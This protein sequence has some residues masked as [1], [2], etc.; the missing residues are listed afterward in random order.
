[1]TDFH[2]EINKIL[3]PYDFSDAAKKALDYASFLAKRTNGEILLVHV[4]EGVLGASEPLYIEA[5]INSPIVYENDIID[6]CKT[7]LTVIAQKLQETGPVKIT[8]VTRAGSAH[9]KIVKIANAVKADLIVMGTH[10]MSGFRR[11]ILGSNTTRV[12]SEATCPV[13]SIQESVP[14]PGF[15][16]I[17]VPFRDEPHSREKVDYAIKMAELFEADIHVLGIDSDGGK[18]AHVKIFREAEQ[19]KTIIKKHRINCE[20]NIITGAH[21]SDQILKHA[22]AKKADLIVIMADMDR[23]SISEYIMGPVVQQ[24]VNHSHIP[25]LTIRPT[26]NA[27]TIDLHGYGW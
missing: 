6:K 16:S 26:F 7:D 8:T 17:L 11:F 22:A 21:V 15:K 27:N 13:L 5:P 23:M 3:V 20:I 1:M 2:F 18:E 4:L 19:I 14:N 9:A 10:G 24:L 25:V 12:I